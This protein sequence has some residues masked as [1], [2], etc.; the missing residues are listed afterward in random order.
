M[1]NATGERQI[2]DSIIKQKQ[3]YELFTNKTQAII[4]NYKIAAVQR[5]LDFDYAC[6]RAT[7]SVA[8]IVY[9]QRQGFH[10][11][12]LGTEEIHI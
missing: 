5:M 6:R 7:P 4:Y 2:A 10:K 9:P 12:F 3:W 8:A 1:D 11:C